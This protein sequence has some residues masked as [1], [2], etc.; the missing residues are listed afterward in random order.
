MTSKK[1]FLATKA[2]RCRVAATGLTSVFLVAVLLAACG[3]EGGGGGGGGAAAPAPNNVPRFAYVT[4]Q[5]DDTVSIYRVHAATG[6]WHHQGFV[7]AGDA[8]ASVT[9]DPSGRY[10]YVANLSSGNVTTFLI[11]ANSGALS[12]VGA[13]F[14]ARTGLSEAGL[15]PP[16][17]EQLPQNSHRARHVARLESDLQKIHVA[18]A[19]L[20]PDERKAEAILRDPYMDISRIS[21]GRA[22]G[23]V[24]TTLHLY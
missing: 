19:A 7:L 1:E 3:G 6:Q 20:S 8:P 21:G 23:K 9:V 15:V 11:D 14:V 4:S 13:K 5:N 24:I 2:A 22:T 18:L 16:Q 17:I 12:K 10:A